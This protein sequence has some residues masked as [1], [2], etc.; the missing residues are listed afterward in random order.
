MTR[1]SAVITGA[2][3]GI[4][5][6]LCRELRSAGYFVIATDE[7][8]GP[9]DADCFVRSDL[10]RFSSD[11]AHRRE[12][13]DAMRAALTD[14]GLSVLVNNAAVQVVAPAEAL[15]DAQWRRTL[16]VNVV[17]PFLLTQ[18]LL[19]ELE[20]GR[21]SV[22]NIG[23]IHAAL[24]KSGFA[25][26]ATSKA[27]IVGMTRALAVELGGRVRVNAVC[28]AAIGTPML[29]SGFDGNPAALGALAE[30]HPAQRIGSPEEVARCVL[31]LADPANKF[32]TGSIVGLD[33]G[34]GARL[35]DPV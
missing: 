4:G 33:G 20:R 32:L 29:T 13:L 8:E 10:A 6:V 34:I 17:A 23:S 9:V 22:V 28:P 15:T 1:K 5:I 14:G 19:G 27:A 11:P 2:A 16:D 21:G 12:V 31:F 18:A 30:A 24:T 7:R 25:C 26:Y 35:H 3:G